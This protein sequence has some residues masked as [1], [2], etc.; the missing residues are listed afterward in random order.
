MTLAPRFLVNFLAGY[1]LARFARRWPATDPGHAAQAGIFRRLLAQFARTA[2]GREQGL[3]A[4]MGAEEFRARVPL[5][6][7]AQFRPWVER[8]AGGEADVLW[9]GR[10]RFFVY[11]S[12][13]TDGVPKLLPV[14]EA[15]LAHFRAALGATLFLHARRA[16]HA[17]VF[18]G[19]HVHTGASTALSEARG[20]YAGFLDGIATLA[21]SPWVEANLHAPPPRVARMPEG[22]EKSAATAAAMLGRDVTLVAGTPRSLLALAEAVCGRADG[23]KARWPHLQAAWPNLECCLHHGAGP[24][25]WT[26]ELRAALGPD[27]AGQEAYAAAEGIF[28]AQEGEAG[29][30]LRLLVEHGLWFEFLPLA[31]YRAE[32][33]AGLGARCVLLADVKPG[34][35][36]VLVVTTPAGLCRCVTGDVVRFGAV[37]PPRLLVVGRVQLQLRAFGEEV[38]EREL[39]EALLDVCGR[40]GWQPVNF[41]VAPYHLRTVPRPQGCHEWWVELRPGTLRTPTGPLLAAELDAALTA[42][43]RA[44]AARRANGSLEA[45]VVRLVAPGTFEQWARAFP[46]QGGAGMLPGCRGDRK[47]AEQLAGLTRFHSATHPPFAG[48]GAAGG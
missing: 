20:A 23:N 35:D 5:R 3:T 6:W 43:H 47:I 9:P 11:T 19:R 44:Y 27:V 10:C 46:A 38:G 13:T 1:R 2:Y 28:A 37:A 26:E 34:V 29:A 17:G 48:P 4:G 12:G 41:H 18:L 22:P 45:P 31:D 24:G 32:L 33:P 36:Y 30:G 39:T 15:M 14:T 16:G 25:L 7:P 40:L 42:S 8:M 21:L